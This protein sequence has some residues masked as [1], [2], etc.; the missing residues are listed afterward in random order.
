MESNIKTT[1]AIKP[2]LAAFADISPETSIVLI[3][4]SVPISCNG[5]EESTLSGNCLGIA[6]SSPVSALLC[7]SPVNIL[8]LEKKMTHGHT[9]KKVDSLSRVTKALASLPVT[10]LFFDCKVVSL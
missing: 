8:R 10:Q 6:K 1:L 4:K 7:F 3:R 9:K 2:S 5:Q